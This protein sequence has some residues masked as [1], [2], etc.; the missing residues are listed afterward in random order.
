MFPLSS[1]SFFGFLFFV[2]TNIFLLRQQEIIYHS[3]TFQFSYPQD[4][5]CSWLG[6]II[7]SLFYSA[8]ACVLLIVL[9]KPQNL[10]SAAVLLYSQWKIHFYNQLLNIKYKRMGGRCRKFFCNMRIISSGTCEQHQQQQCKL[11][12]S[13]LRCY[14]FLLLYSSHSRIKYF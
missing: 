4:S 13:A 8:S 11:V 14:V 12:T 3:P 7:S 10:L 2:H 1:S 9:W 5:Y 6:F